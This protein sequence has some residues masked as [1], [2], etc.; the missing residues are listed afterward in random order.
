M[1]RYWLYKN[2][3]AGGPAGYCGDWASMV[4][5]DASQKQWGGH[6]ATRSP[7]VGRRLDEDVRSGDVVV[8]YQT[9]TRCIVGFCVITKVVGPVGDRRLH[10]KPIEL[11]SVPFPIHDRK[12]G[13]CLELS[14]AVRGPVML[15]E[16]TSAEMQELITLTGSPLRILKGQA[17]AGGYRP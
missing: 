8:A 3:T 17:K 6:Y 2:N 10:L 16:L 9:D 4:F 14:W 7:Q 1:T 13:T 5:N 11:L 12:A 15:A